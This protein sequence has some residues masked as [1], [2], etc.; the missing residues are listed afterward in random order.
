REDPYEVVEPDD[1]VVLREPVPVGERQEGATQGGPKDRE[2][3]EQEGGNSE[4]EQAL[5]AHG[6]VGS[7]SWARS[8]TAGGFD[9]RVGCFFLDGRPHETLPVTLSASLS[10]SAVSVGV[11]SSCTARV[12]RA[13]A[14]S[15]C[16]WSSA[17]IGR[18]AC[19]VR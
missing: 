15:R 14:P 18:A 5:E 17:E 1:L 9:R 4:P 11:I 3:V 8:T 19:R 13:R 2:P 16:L 10:A 6:V 7:A 12:I